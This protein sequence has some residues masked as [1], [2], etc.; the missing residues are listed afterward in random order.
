M[1]SLYCVDTPFVF[2]TSYLVMAASIKT[3][4]EPYRGIALMLLAMALLSSMDAVAKW[5]ME[6]SATSIQL[7]ALRS[8]I[9]SP[10][11]IAFFY[12]KGEK[13]ELMPTR[14]V[15][16]ALRGVF[17]FVAPF[18]FFLGIQHLPLTAA[19]VVFFSSIF[20][21]TLLSIFVLNE[22]VGFH[23]WAAVIVGY[24]GVAVAMLPWEGGSLKGYLL[25]LLSS[26]AYSMVFVSG[27]YLARTESVT[28][29]VLSYN[30][31]VGFVSI[32]LLPWFWQS[33]DLHLYW[34]IVFLSFLAVAGHFAM[35]TAFSIAEASQITPF[36]YTG[37]IWTL[38]FDI[39][40]WQ[41]Y[42][43]VY[44]LVGAIIIVVSSL[45][46]IQRERLQSV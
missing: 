21:T 30:M 18:A 33:I 1:Q 12:I 16:Q 28:S 4:A 43:S 17:G 42:P 25:V 23:R 38:L 46:V 37:V 3:R 45:Y 41:S 5:L 44:T 39:V 29:L 26:F 36:E 20:F 31:G 8:I 11:L 22:K 34:G 14:P 13:A 35:T 24:C 15:A 10:C 40:I 32:L 19:V 27:K 6:H 9:I 2:N 7:L